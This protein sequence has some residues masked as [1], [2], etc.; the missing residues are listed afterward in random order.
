MAVA[1]FYHSEIQNTHISHELVAMS[2]L[3]ILVHECSSE[4]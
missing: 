1:C 2:Y 3:A 4:D